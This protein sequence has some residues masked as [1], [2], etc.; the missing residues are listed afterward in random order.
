MGVDRQLSLQ[1]VRINPSVGP[2]AA[3]NS[4]AALCSAVSNVPPGR[5]GA[6]EDGDERSEAL[7]Y[8]GKLKKLELRSLEERSINNTP[9]GQKRLL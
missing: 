7:S 8:E 1:D 5:C 9:R 3:G 6:D 4:A 2:S